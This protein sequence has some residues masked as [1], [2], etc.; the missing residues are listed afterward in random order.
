MSNL[1]CTVKIILLIQMDFSLYFT[2]K[3]VIYVMMYLDCC[4]ADIS[5]MAQESG[6]DGLSLV[7]TDSYVSS[8]PILALIAKCFYERGSSYRSIIEIGNIYILCIWTN[9]HDL[10]QRRVPDDIFGVLGLWTKDRR[11]S[12]TS[13][14]GL[15]L[16][17]IILNIN[18]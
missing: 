3:N 9:R 5:G 12:K 18:K 7:Q 16:K 8:K 17:Q 1:F 6:L 13:Y 10:I 4:I 11:R 2:L 15:L 14:W